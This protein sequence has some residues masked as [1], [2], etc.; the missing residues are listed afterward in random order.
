MAEY[1]TSSPT[2]ANKAGQ[3]KTENMFIP[4]SIGKKALEV[5][6][7]FETVASVLEYVSSKLHN[8]NMSEA[9]YLYREAWF[10]MSNTTLCKKL[11]SET[12]LTKWLNENTKSGNLK[13][14]CEK[15]GSG[16]KLLKELKR[17]ID[18][19]EPV[20]DIAKSIHSIY[21]DSIYVININSEKSD[22][23]S[24]I[25]DE[26]RKSTRQFEAVMDII[27]VINQFA[28]H[29][30]REYIDYNLAVFE[31]AKKLFSLA[32]KYADIVISLS[33]ETDEW[34][35]AINNDYSWWNATKSIGRS[36]DA[37][38]Y[39]DLLDRREKRK[40]AMS[41]YKLDRSEIQRQRR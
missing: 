3:L 18:I 41:Q 14:F 38:Q 35:D 16:F 21:S 26:V 17:G 4:D 24:V 36:A 28:P 33:K 8:M 12:E 20:V 10:K 31:G 13:T 19:I 27:K 11:W 32:D 40:K 9:E 1:R 5:A 25:R 2:I 15:L 30:F 29:G 39:L 37:N 23:C 34:Y 7:D 6:I 22:R